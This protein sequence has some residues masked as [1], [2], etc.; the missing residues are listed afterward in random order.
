M[1]APG[2]H[3]LSHQGFWG[4]S[5]PSRLW[6]DE[7]SGG[8]GEG[9]FL[10]SHLEQEKGLHG[11]DAKSSERLWGK[12]ACFIFVLGDIFRGSDNYHKMTCEMTEPVDIYMD[13]GGTKKALSCSSG[14]KVEWEG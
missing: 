10:R 11:H 14:G 12:L 8:V 6:S 5:G 1:G 9:P 4:R 2:L 3:M 13:P 7:I